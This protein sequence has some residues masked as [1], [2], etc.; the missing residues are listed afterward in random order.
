MTVEL[1]AINLLL[2]E[3]GQKWLNNFQDEDKQ[4]ARILVSHLMLISEIEFERELIKRIEIEAARHKGCIALFGVRELDEGAQ[5][6]IFDAE[7]TGV[8]A[9]PRGVDIGSEGRIA[10]ILR[11]MARASNGKF[12]NHPDIIEMREK[13]CVAIFFIDDFIGSGKRVKK[14]V[15]DF[16]SN[17]TIRSWHSFHLIKTEVFSYSGTSDGIRKIRQ[18]KTRPR[19]NIVRSCPTISTLLLVNEQIDELKILCK[20]YARTNKMNYPFGFGSVGALIVFEHSCPNNCPQIL[21]GSPKNNSWEPLFLGKAVASN[22]RSVFPPEITRRDPVNLLIAAGEKRIADA[23]RN[24]VRRPLPA[25]WLATLSLFEK[26]VR[27]IDAVEGVTGLNHSESAK[28]IEECVT[29][30]LLTQKWRLSVFGQQELKATRKMLSYAQK[31]LPNSVEYD[32]YPHALRR[33]DEC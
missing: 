32:Y 6:H 26:G 15:E 20:N 3:R 17:A 8:N 31:K 2:T 21:W 22:A 27:R 28:V 19:I 13:K 12:I 23:A 10:T 9:T 33:Y 25:E 1:A 24:L 7:G 30:G 16:Y 18:S 11:N 29:A 4:F 5:E 14:Y